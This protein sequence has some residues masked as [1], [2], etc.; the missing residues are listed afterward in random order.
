MLNISFR[1]ANRQRIFLSHR[2]SGHD[3]LAGRLC[4]AEEPHMVYR[5]HGA[6][7]HVEAVLA[8]KDSPTLRERLGAAAVVSRLGV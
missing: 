6:S 3:Y 4:D 5:E 8:M 7:V 1:S 2:H